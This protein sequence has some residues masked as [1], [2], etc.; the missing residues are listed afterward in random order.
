MSPYHFLSGHP[1]SLLIHSGCMCSHRAQRSLLQKEAFPFLCRGQAAPGWGNPLRRSHRLGSWVQHPCLSR[2]DLT[3]H[4]VGSQERGLLPS[5]IWLPV[6]PPRQALLL[7]CPLTHPECRLLARACSVLDGWMW[8]GGFVPRCPGWWEV[9]FLL[10]VHSWSL[11]G[12]T[13]AH[14]RPGA[15]R[16]HQVRSLPQIERSLHPPQAP[17]GTPAR[18]ELPRASGTRGACTLG[19]SQLWAEILT[20]P[21]AFAVRSRPWI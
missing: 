7:T 5:S 4:R 19:S 3:H 14:F 21:P 13:A 20:P 6:L 10:K 11:C 16:A 9:E 12:S 2:S 1:S 17:L 8:G 15:P 18:R